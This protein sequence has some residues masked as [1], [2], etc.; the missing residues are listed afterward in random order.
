MA[1]ALSA[2]SRVLAFDP[3]KVSGLADWAR[4]Y[5][6]IVAKWVQPLEQCESQLSAELETSKQAMLHPPTTNFIIQFVGPFAMKSLDG[7]PLDTVRWGAQS[8]LLL[9]FDAS[10][11][12]S[13][14]GVDSRGR[15]A[16]FPLGEL[17]S[18]GP[19]ELPTLPW[20]Q[21]VV[22]APDGETRNE[23]FQRMLSTASTHMSHVLLH[24]S[25]INECR[26]TLGAIRGLLECCNQ[27]PSLS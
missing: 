7:R 25:R 27:L 13:G 9:H 5:R 23:V 4:S 20:W 22:S 12:W 24:E 16:V 3:S 18:S 15:S 8:A 10:G 14:G 17:P 6:D 1:A 26:L 2:Y 21:P 11:N 19:F